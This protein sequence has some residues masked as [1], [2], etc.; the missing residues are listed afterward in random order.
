LMKFTSTPD[1]YVLVASR[2]GGTLTSTT[3]P[4]PVTLTI[5]NVSGTKQMN[6][7]FD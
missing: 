7:T 3:S 6:A 1:R 5:G 2:K 4:V